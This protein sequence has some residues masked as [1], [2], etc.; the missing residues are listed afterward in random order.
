VKAALA[1]LYRV[2][3]APNPFADCLAPKFR[4]DAV[5]IRH[6]EGGRLAKVLLELQRH[7]RD[8]FDHLVSHLAEALFF[9][10]CRF[11]EW[12]LLTR[13]RLV[14]DGA[15]RI[16]AARLRVK[17]GKHR[18]VPV[19]P[20][21]GESLA[22]WAAF[23]EGFKGHRLR[24]GHVGFAGSELVFPGRDGAPLNNQAFNKKLAAACRAAGTEVITAHGLR[25]SA[26][27]LL[28]NER[29]RNLRE[30]QD[31]LGHKSLSTTARYT[32]IDRGRLRSVVDDLKL[33]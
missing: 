6:L 33:A 28:L 16:T 30:L 4:P 1:L 24:R 15:G 26:A 22:E 7:R 31:L 32:H 2:L 23:L 21:L 25:H 10:A 27:S 9:T 11:H 19:M 18:D 14:Y 29:G 17:G 8:Y 5:E 13:D 12:A 20:R 3:E